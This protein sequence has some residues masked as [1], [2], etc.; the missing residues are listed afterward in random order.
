MMIVKMMLLV[1]VV[2][3]AVIDVGGASVAGVEVVVVLR[4][5]DEGVVVQGSR[6]GWC[7]GIPFY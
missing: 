7:S 1:G 3:V 2:V 4:V 5:G 6:R